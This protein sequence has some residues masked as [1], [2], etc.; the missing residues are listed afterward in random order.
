MQA[1]VMVS[2]KDDL[3]GTYAYV[4]KHASH[5]KLHWPFTDRAEAGRPF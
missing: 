2:S 3:L 4:K 1:V 5:W